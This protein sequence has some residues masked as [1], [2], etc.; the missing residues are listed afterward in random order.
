MKLRAEDQNRNLQAVGEGRGAVF[1]VCSFHGLLKVLSY[2]IQGHLT[3]GSATHNELCPF[4]INHQSR[5]YPIGQ[6]IGT[7]V[8]SWGYIFPNASTLCESDLKIGS[9]SKMQHN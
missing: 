2:T 8:Y 3:R 4:N 7:I 1:P 5:K 6:F 9:A